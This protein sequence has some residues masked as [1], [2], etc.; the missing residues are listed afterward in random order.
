MSNEQRI[1]NSEFFKRER[2]TRTPEV[3]EKI[4]KAQL[5]YHAKKRADK[6]SGSALEGYIF[7][8]L[9]NGRRQYV[10]VIAKLEGSIL[11][12]AAYKTNCKSVVFNCQSGDPPSNTEGMAYISRSV[13]FQSRV[14]DIVF[15]N[16]DTLDCIRDAYLMSTGEV[17]PDFDYQI[18]TPPNL[19][20]IEVNPVLNILKNMSIQH[21][22][23]IT[24]IHQ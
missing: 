11:H 20:D 19:L 1:P 2:V 15:F 17:C 4:R 5:A 8:G 12:I 13:I 23:E 3:V 9:P 10:Y 24:R 6:E 14:C 7:R 22:Q 18:F 16:S 21:K